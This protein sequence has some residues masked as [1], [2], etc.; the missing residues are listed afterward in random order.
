MPRLGY[1]PHDFVSGTVLAG[2]A[3]NVFLFSLC[4]AIALVCFACP[5]DRTQCRVFFAH[6]PGIARETQVVSSR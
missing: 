2:R 6:L 4:L 5:P 1:K 3:V